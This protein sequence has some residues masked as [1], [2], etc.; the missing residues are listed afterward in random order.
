MTKS[1]ALQNVLDTLTGFRA[2]Q[3][4]PSTIKIDCGGESPITLAQ[5]WSKSAINNNTQ[6][7]FLV[8]PKDLEDEL[9]LSNALFVRYGETVFFVSGDIVPPTEDGGYWM[10][11]VRES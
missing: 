3:G 9:E 7:V 8:I 5:G 1:E 6:I 10:L 2:S 11:P 4:A